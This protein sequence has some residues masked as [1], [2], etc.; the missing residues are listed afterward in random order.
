MKILVLGT[1]FNGI[2]RDRIESGAVKVIQNQMHYLSQKHEM[3]LVCLKN[4][5]KLYANQHFLE[6]NYEKD[7]PRQQKASLT[8]KISKQLVEIVDQVKPNI[9]FNNTC[10]HLNGAIKHFN[11]P[12]IL[13]E[14]ASHFVPF[15]F[16]NT[17]AKLRKIDFFEANQVYWTGVSLFQQS[18]FFLS[19][20]REEIEDLK[21]KKRFKFHDIICVHVK[22]TNQEMIP[23]EFD[24]KFGVLISRMDPVKSP[25]RILKIY[26]KTGLQYPI[27][28]FTHFD[29]TRD[30]GTDAANSYREKYAQN[31][32]V[33]LNVSADRSHL[34]T[35]LSQASFCLGTFGEASPVVS[36]EAGLCGVPYI[37][38]SH[39]ENSGESELIDPKYY[40]QVVKTKGDMPG[41]QRKLIEQSLELN[42]S[43]RL[44]M[45]SHFHEKFSPQNFI[46]R[47]EK[48]IHRCMEKYQG[49]RCVTA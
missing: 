7:L 43:D 37:I 19:K 8:R 42:T 35:R 26:Q 3:H 23:R 24:K 9:I 14:H 30:S 16:E 11:R 29:S 1:L 20:E 36:I 10:K 28:F 22:D 39:A 48:I 4:S 27:E 18:N 2:Y 25:E 15:G 45:S 49:E 6:F 31:S 5:D 12:S 33:S 17:E 46:A 47:H 21:D 13:F 40:F 34:L 41:Q 32:L 38:H 44:D